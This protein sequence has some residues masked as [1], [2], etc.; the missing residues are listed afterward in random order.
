MT[1]TTPAFC[2]ECNAA[3]RLERDRYDSLKLVCACGTTRNTRVSTVL[4]E[5][6][7]Q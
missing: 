3:I 5:E 2:D 6:W 4:P 1:D 7:S